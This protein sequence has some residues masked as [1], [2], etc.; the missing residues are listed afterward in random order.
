MSSFDEY[1]TAAIRTFRRVPGAENAQLAS[2]TLGLAGEMGEVAEHVKKFLAHG[3]ELDVLHM[4]AELGDVL[5][6][7][8]ILGE[9]CGLNLQSIAQHN[10]D[11]L[12]ARYPNGF[13][14]EIR[15]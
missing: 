10:I 6:Y 2:M 9:L 15:K 5:W 11:K 13:T 1:Q 14:A 8:T 7:I 3:R 4:K 12:K